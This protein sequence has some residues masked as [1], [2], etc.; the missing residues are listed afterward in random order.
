MSYVFAPWAFFL[1]R[2]SLVS[3]T[4]LQVEAATSL[5]ASPWNVIWRVFCPAVWRGGLVAFLLIYCT[6]LGYFI[7][8]RMLGGNTRDLAGNVI[9]RFLELGDFETASKIALALLFSAIPFA[10]LFL[11]WNQRRSRLEG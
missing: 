10:L 7:T 1:M 11:W 3:V 9:I 8:P 4:G 5:G 2:L 6:S